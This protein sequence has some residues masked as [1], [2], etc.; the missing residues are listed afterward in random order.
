[1]RGRQAVLNAGHTVIRIIRFFRFLRIL[2]FLRF[3]WFLRILRILRKRKGGEGFGLGVLRREGSEIPGAV[4]GGRGGNR[5]VRRNEFIESLEG[6]GDPLKPFKDVRTIVGRAM[7]GRR[8]LD[9]LTGN[10]GF[11]IVLTTVLFGTPLH[12]APDK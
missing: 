3:L 1:M 7:P 6:I 4:H 10:R 9:G 11:G 2:R 12:P 8:C 5:S